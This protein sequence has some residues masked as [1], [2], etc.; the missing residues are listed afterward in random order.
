MLIKRWLAAWVLLSLII[1]GAISL[2]RWQASSKRAVP[3]VS[4]V[5]R[6]P[7]IEPARPGEIVLHG[8]VQA[9]A[10]RRLKAP[11]EGTVI[12]VTSAEGAPVA[13]GELL[14]QIKPRRPEAVANL[15]PSPPPSDLPEPEAL[16]DLRAEVDTAAAAWELAERALKKFAAAKPE[17]VTAR[18]EIDN[19]QRRSRALA[20]ANSR[21]SA[22][23]ARAEEKA[24]PNPSAAAA[25][26]LEELQQAREIARRQNQI[27]YDDLQRQL[28]KLQDLQGE[29]EDYEAL[30]R[31][32]DQHQ[33]RHAY[34]TRR[35][36]ELTPLLT[37]AS[38]QP[39][40]AA[41]LAASQPLPAGAVVS[42]EAGTLRDFRLRPGLAV[43]RGQEIGVVELA[44]GSR[45]VF[46]VPND[47]TGE[48]QVGLRLR[49]TPATG[50]AFEGRISQ[51][52]R[53]SQQTLVY[54]LPLGENPLPPPRTALVARLAP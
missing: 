12:A 43:R 18:E 34:L 31:E 40:E 15:Q 20:E 25:R 45:L 38:R 10:T 36:K 24:G 44:G 42:P 21:A 54:V 4:P 3:T 9:A 8:Q 27:E 6:A 19:L 2:Y 7:F 13:R 47:Q 51:L 33:A 23:Y 53:E 49:I 16:R 17:V 46:P 1:I 35:L 30:Q 14:G 39:A 48:L 32:R 52:A 29:I 41:T 5:I 26:K 50:M 22:D 37:R 11:V 28:A